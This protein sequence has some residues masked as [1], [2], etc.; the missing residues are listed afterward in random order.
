MNEIDYIRL[1]FV[2]GFLFL[3]LSHLHAWLTSKY[4]NARWWFIVSA[5]GLA[6]TC[7]TYISH[8]FIVIPEPYE[9]LNSVINGT[10][11]VL[12]LLYVTLREPKR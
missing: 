9:T 11:M 4:W 7:W 3:T 10:A 1:I 8:N 5:V 6:I 12:I 2:V